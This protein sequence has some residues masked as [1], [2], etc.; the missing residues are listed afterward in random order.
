MSNFNRPINFTRD[1]IGKYDKKVLENNDRIQQIID[2]NK[3]KFD[4]D[5]YD[6]KEVKT[7]LNPVFDPSALVGNQID[8]G[9]QNIINKKEYDPFLHYLNE[10][11]LYDKNTKIRY[12]VDY[13]IIDSSMRNKN[14][15]NIINFSSKL[16]NNSLSIKRNMLYINIDNNLISN[17]NVG[18]KI[19]INDLNYFEQIYHSSNSGNPI[20]TFVIGKS[21]IK[22]NMNPNTNI[23]QYTNYINVDTA[24]SKVFI[25]GVKGVKTIGFVDYNDD[26]SAFIG[27]IPISFINNEHQIYITP[28][29]ESI[30]PDTN[31]FYILMP[32]ISDGTNIATTSIY[33]IT[34][35][36][37]HY[38]FIPVNQIN[39]SY[40]VNEYQINGYQ[41]IEE[42]GYDYIAFEIYPPLDLSIPNNNTYEFLNFGNSINIGLI[43]TIILGYPSPNNYVINFTKLFTN[44]ILI[45]M[46]DSSF[47]NPNKT[48][49]DSGPYKNN[50]LYFQSIENISEIQFIEIDT[51]FYNITE[52]KNEIEKK[53][54]QKSRN[55]TD[56]I[57]NYDLNYNVIFNADLST[58][59]VKFESYKNTILQVPIQSTNPIINSSDTTIG[60]GSYTITIKH[61][62]H[63][64]TTQ[65]ENILF[66]G[67]IEH[68]GL[69][70]SDL[71]G[72]HT[73]TILD[74]DTYTFTL[75]NINLNPIKT[76]TYGG[77]SVKVHVPSPMKF[78]FNYNDTIG[79]VLGFSD[80]GL[81]TSIT[82]FNYIIKNIDPYINEQNLQKYKKNNIITLG[83]FKYFLITCKE[84]PI[85]TNT[86]KV[87]NIF[88]KILTSNDSNINNNLLINTFSLTP[89]FYYDP[90]RELYQL[91]LQFY[92][93]NGELVDF[94]NDDHTFTLEITTF[95]NIPE[96]TNITTNVTIDK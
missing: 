18:D 39:A 50:R 90:I 13:V 31:T 74:K 87:T 73:V 72:L 15:E 64:L 82:N 46:I 17:F 7:S 60:T 32:Y 20:I 79:N 44:V 19:S 14:S 33:N 1:I 24:N 84:L 16:P 65:T 56:T 77:R 40:P 34:F 66:S 94:G 88:A 49:F 59:I 51:G 96:L 26:T 23:N 91:T 45:R 47:N 61:Q 62:N 70:S 83:Y 41:I 69:Y 3:N 36:F 10:K 78:F 52:L 42:K 75:N 92:Y 35:K 76:V 71:N 89:Q 57:F 25:S 43:Q 12:N 29:G 67:F 93:P 22:I 8:F 54:S 5:N 86:D 85:V 48:I 11:G 27:N 81:D 37:N 95:D 9:N 55:I 4:S 28:P 68:L 30:L 58:N 63:G 80:V 21:Y 2:F 53:F 38:N 6:F